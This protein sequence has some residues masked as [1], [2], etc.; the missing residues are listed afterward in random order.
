M[1]LSDVLNQVDPPL[2]VAT[3][4]GSPTSRGASE[5]VDEDNF[6]DSDELPNTQ[7]LSRAG[8][9]RQRTEDY[10]QY[11]VTTA[12]NVKLRKDDEVK[13]VRFSELSSPEQ[14]I[15]IYA[16][17]M[18]TL[19]LLEMLHPPEAA[20]VI[21]ESLDGYLEWF[22]YA[23]LLA[24]DCIRY[25]QDDGPTNIILNILVRNPS[26]GVTSEVKNDTKKFGIL[27]TRTRRLLTQRRSSMK[28]IMVISM[29]FVK[30]GNNWV[31]NPDAPVD[32]IVGLVEKLIHDRKGTPKKEI[33]LT[34]GI[35]ARFAFLR[36]VLL[37][38]LKDPT[39]A[40]EEYWKRVD[41]KLRGYRDE[42]L[43]NATL[44]KRFLDDLI[45]DVAKYGGKDRAESIDDSTFVLED[46]D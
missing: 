19:K 1:L 18:A 42:K 26:W 37:N 34:V 45:T 36:S 38:C 35:L 22:S 13:V 30:E 46:L 31:Q 6:L 11:A 27:K 33:K 15:T 21:P 9:K 17:N 41:A 8:R 16:Q 25:V 2:P 24:P 39:V 14:R 40:G 32:D 3:P 7:S 5:G 10:T 44:T 43:D 29:G 12:R 28:T 23:S 4:T 20:Y